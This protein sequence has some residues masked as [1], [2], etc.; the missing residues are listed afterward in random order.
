[1]KLQYKATIKDFINAQNYGIYFGQKIPNNGSL[2]FDRGDKSTFAKAIQEIKNN[3]KVSHWIWYV[4]PSPA[5]AKASLTAQFFSVNQKKV[6][7]YLNDKILFK[8][9]VRIIELIS[10]KLRKYKKKEVLIEILGS[11]DYYKLVKSL[12]IFYPILINKD[13]KIDK[14]KYLYDS[15]LKF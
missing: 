12:K 3:K 13:I 6:L 7:E 1:M 2:V 11:I 9:Y 10:D 5:D 14:I 4:I 8:R 15:L